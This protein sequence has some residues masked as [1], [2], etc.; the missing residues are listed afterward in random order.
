ML[1]RQLYRIFVSILLIP[2]L[3]I[4][5]YLLIYNYRLIY[6]HHTDM[7]KS[8]N[9]RVRSIIYDVTTALTNVCE[10]ISTNEGLHTVLST[11]YETSHQAMNALMDFSLLKELNN[12]YP[13]ISSLKVYMNNATISSYGHV[14]H[15]EASDVAWFEKALEHPGYKWGINT[16]TDKYSNIYKE[17]Q[18]VYPIVIPNSETDA[19]LVISVSGNYLKNRINNNTLNVD[20]AV[21]DDTI[22]FSTMQNEDQLIDFHA[23]Q[24]VPYFSYTGKDTYNGE[25]ALVEVS[26]LKPVKT[27]DFIYIFSVDKEAINRLDRLLNT[28]ILIIAFTILI[29][30]IVIGLYTRQLTFRITTL[31]TEMHRV[32]AGDYNIIDTFKGN[33]ELADLFY[34]L[35]VMIHAIKTRDEKIYE[36]SLEEQRLLT[37]QGAMEF[38]LLSSKINPHFLY[39]TLETIRMKAFNSGNR[40]VSNAVKLLGK[41][42]RYNLES[43]SETK[44]LAEELEYIQL[45]LDIQ[46]L[47]FG[48]RIQYTVSIDSELDPKALY[49]LPLLI[50]PLVENAL[51]HGLEDTLENG[52]IWI[53]CIKRADQLRVEIEDNGKGMYPETLNQVRKKISVSEMKD[54]H[55]FGLHNIQQRLLI[56]YGEA[57]GLTFDTKPNVGTCIGFSIPLSQME[58]KL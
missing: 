26:A 21:N 34:D 8:D 20:L 35:K 37:H 5:L 55:S 30:T 51:L 42:M 40:E 38:Q 57:S 44:S 22:F 47:R 56:L 23:Y 13:E 9:L 25:K 3:L 52:M 7:L 29:P 15:V 19:L 6:D 4:G 10:I 54:K 2:A 14:V 28:E 43:S 18:V 1:R 49:I 58:R 36:I 17:L 27:S 11:E 41:Y 16:Y 12:R 45:Y 31:R 32:T 53:R 46:K 33:D 50:Q 48:E 24:N 39:N